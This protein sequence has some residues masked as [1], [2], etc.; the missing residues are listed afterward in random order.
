M[1]TAPVAIH[2]QTAGHGEKDPRTVELEATLVRT[3][4]GFCGRE[5]NLDV[6]VRGL[7]NEL[8]F[9]AKPERG[10]RRVVRAGKGRGKETGRRERERERSERAEG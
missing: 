8:G 2:S 5:E 7:R 10:A 3:N 6:V 9:G 1:S 4:L